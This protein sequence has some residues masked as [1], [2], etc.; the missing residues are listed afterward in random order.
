M[1]TDKMLIAKRLVD[2]IIVDNMSVDK[3]PIQNDMLPFVWLGSP[4]ADSF[5][6]NFS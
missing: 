5:Y 4:V 3:M 1:F 2:K 6:L